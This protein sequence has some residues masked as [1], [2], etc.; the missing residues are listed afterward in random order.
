MHDRKLDSQQ[1]EAADEDDALNDAP[2]RPI[3]VV[4]DIPANLVAMQAALAPLE[5]EIVTAGS[6]A[7][8]LRL[9]LE[10]E[11]SLV[12]LDLQMPEIDG[13]ETAALIRERARTRRLPII[14]VTA[15]EHDDQ[16]MLRGYR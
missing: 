13:Y 8:A 14:F 3:L 6:G 1:E 15:H 11:F 7:D 2:K 12:L 5:R 10:R 4:D 9:L 16:A